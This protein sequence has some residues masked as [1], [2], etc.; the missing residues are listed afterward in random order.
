MDARPEWFDRAA[1]VG[2][3][4]LFFPNDE[5]DQRSYREAKAICAECVCKKPCLERAI[6][7][8]ERHGFWGGLSA[9]QVKGVRADRGL[10]RLNAVEHGTRGCYQKGCRRQECCDAQSRYIRDLRVARLAA[11]KV[12]K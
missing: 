6:A 12:A 7:N 9:R 8:G 3:T 4:D 11:Q 1:C 10:K 5:A 2:K